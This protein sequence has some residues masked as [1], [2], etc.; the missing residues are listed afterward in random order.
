MD[1]QL[2]HRKEPD[3]K[4]RIIKPVK[5]EGGKKTPFRTIYLNENGG[6]AGYY[7]RVDLPGTLRTLTREDGKFQH[8]VNEEGE[9]QPRDDVYYKGLVTATAD[10]WLDVGCGADK[11]QIGPELGFGHVVGNHHEAPV[12]LIKASQGNRSLGWDFLPPGSERFEYTDDEG[13]VLRRPQG[14]PIKM[15]ERQRAKSRWLVCR[16]AV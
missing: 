15:G 10:K 12:L 2:I 9:F 1:G 7:N 8:L 16:Q 4:E 14:P 11:N 3:Q 6:T 5:L 13:T